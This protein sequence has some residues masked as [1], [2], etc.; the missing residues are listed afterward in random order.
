[1]ITVVEG[2]LPESLADGFS[3]STIVAWDTETG[4]L[5]WR[6]DRLALCQLHAPEMGTVLVR[7]TDEQPARL[8]DLL[9]SASITKVFHHAPFD[10]RFMRRSFG[11]RANNV[12]CTKVAS[13]LLTPAAPSRDHSLAPLVD[14]YL[15][16][17]LEKGA[18][19]VSDWSAPELSDKQIEYAVRD[20]EFLVPLLEKQR[21]D[22][23]RSGAV[24]GLRAMLQ[25]PADPGRGICSRDR[26][27]VRLLAVPCA[28]I[29]QAGASAHLR[30]TRTLR[31]SPQRDWPA[32]AGGTEPLA[33]WCG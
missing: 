11:A 18:E 29:R 19:R 3:K 5:D 6:T 7:M 13:K 12:V 14:R 27:R 32:S 1:M 16:V 24:G 26:G 30:K 22:S 25:L 4:G 31:H 10:L 28:S 8:S 23:G 21:K 9:A 2:D 33:H 15:G 17:T 20:V